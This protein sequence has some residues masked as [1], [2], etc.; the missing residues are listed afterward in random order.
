MLLSTSSI[1]REQLSLGAVVAD[2]LE[3]DRLTAVSYRY[4]CGFSW[5]ALVTRGQKWEEQVGS[6]KVRSI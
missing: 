3:L 1:F 4:F 6:A 5:V 2:P